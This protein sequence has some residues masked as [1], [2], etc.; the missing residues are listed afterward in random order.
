MVAGA[1]R[2]TSTRVAVFAAY[3]A[4]GLGYAV[5]VTSLPAL[6][7]R[8][9]VDDTVVTLIVLGVAIAAAGGSVLAN[10]LA[11]RFGSRT[12]LV[13]GLLLQAASL[14]AI[15]LPTPVP[16]FV[17]LFA[18]Y[19]IGLGCVDA[20]TAMQGVI[21]QRAH[22]IPLL[23]GFFSA[24]TAAAIAGALL[25]S[26]IAASPVAAG[27][28]IGTAGVAILVVAVVGIRLFAREVPIETALP[29]TERA[30]LPRAGIWAFGFVILA[31]FV[32]DSAVSTWSTVYLQDDLGAL[33]A[34]APLGY[35]A[36]Q[37][38]VL[39][40]RLATDRLLG[41]MSRGRL[42][43]GAIVVSVIGVVAVAFLPF[44]IAAILGFALAGAATGILIPVTFGAA[45]DLSPAHSD[46]VIARVN[47]FNY[48]GAILGAVIVGLLADGPGLAIA[49]LI[50][51]GVLAASL[52]VV[53][54]F[55]T[56]FCV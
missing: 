43:T 39:I 18:V 1:A 47:I 16:L 25:V 17:S 13:V 11:V 6:K 46:Q 36:Y 52:W 20:A 14:P 24:Y 4:Q 32:V 7:Q 30:R 42:V 54:W 34:L 48:A 44:E 22:G 19:G 37:V 12:A 5:V 33:P 23:G 53:R 27:V 35:A 10:A 38:C 55:R 56:T 8:Q 9:G 26:A 15:A 31:V 40:T 50:P 45:G 41:I 51:A 21:V 29:A 28:A 3:A 49:F 2:S